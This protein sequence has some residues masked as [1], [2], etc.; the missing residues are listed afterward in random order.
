MVD[1]FSKIGPGTLQFSSL[2][3]NVHLP[4]VVASQ[5]TDV[6][7]RVV[8][9]D[10]QGQDNTAHSPLRSSGFLFPCTSSRQVCYSRC[11]KGKEESISAF[12]GHS[13][14]LSLRLENQI[15][16]QPNVPS[17][18]LALR[19]S[20][21]FGPDW[22]DRYGRGVEQESASSIWRGA[23]Q[24]RLPSELQA[25]SRTAQVASRCTLQ[26]SIHVRGG[27]GAPVSADLIAAF[28]TLECMGREVSQL[29]ARR[30]EYF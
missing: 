23:F 8:R 17:V 27:G 26:I 11:S 24:R 25:R 14:S 9:L 29:T 21:E 22:E 30:R 5:N 28:K 15:C 3:S 20:Q 19:L 7:D 16:R 12:P 18:V 13:A 2:V 10:E 6:W 1:A 4:S